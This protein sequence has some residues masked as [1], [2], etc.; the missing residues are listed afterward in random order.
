MP[1][2]ALVKRLL[3]AARMLSGLAVF[4]SCVVT[5]RNL[6]VSLCM[7]IHSWYADAFVTVY[8]RWCLA[9]VQPGCRYE[10]PL[11]PEEAGLCSGTLL[12][13][14][15]LVVVV[16]VVVVVLVGVVAAFVRRRIR[17][18]RSSSN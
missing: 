14:P 4:S 6:W 12:L 7:C 11:W 9:A 1:P 18:S 2:R 10:M 8:V 16:V 17:S 13:I 15:P 5:G 3:C